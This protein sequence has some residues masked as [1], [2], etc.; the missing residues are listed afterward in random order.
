M[1]RLTECKWNCQP[2]LQ[3]NRSFDKMT[4]ILLLG[5]PPKKQAQYII[6]TITII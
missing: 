3:E 2:K 4:Y 5:N 6:K 1:L